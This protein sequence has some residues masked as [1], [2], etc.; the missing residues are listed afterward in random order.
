MKSTL[1]ALED[2]LREIEFLEDIRM[3]TTLDLFKDS[4]TDVRAASYSI[5]VISEAVSGGFLKTGSQLI[6]T[7]HGMRSVP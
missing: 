5:L 6:L 4:S 2:I 3:R 1:I 7:C